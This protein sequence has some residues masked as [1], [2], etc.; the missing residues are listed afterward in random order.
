MTPNDSIHT[1]HTIYGVDPVA[2]VAPV[3]PVLGLGPV[4]GLVLM[5]GQ[6]R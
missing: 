2:L 3:A 4:P 6:A 1:V 5:R